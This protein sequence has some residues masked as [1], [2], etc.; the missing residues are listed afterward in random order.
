MGQEVAL[1]WQEVALVGRDVALV[2]REVALVGSKG[3]YPAAQC[4]SSTL[5][6]FN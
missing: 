6:Y 3:H 4:P 5:I 2:G 1:V